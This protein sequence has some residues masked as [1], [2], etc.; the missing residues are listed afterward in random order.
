VCHQVTPRLCV[1]R[2]LLQV[3]LLPLCVYKVLAD[4]AMAYDWPNQKPWVRL[5]VLS[6]H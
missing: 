1:C 2:G 3:L 5:P 4:S 6:A